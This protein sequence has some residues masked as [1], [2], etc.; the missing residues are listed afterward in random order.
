M[1]RVSS[2]RIG[3]PLQVALAALVIGATALTLAPGQA[4]ARPRRDSGA[5]CADTLADGTI[6]FFLPGETWG[7]G[8]T[9]GTLYVCSVTGQWFVHEDHHVQDRG[10]RP[11]RGGR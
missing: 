8:A 5:R 9:T 11:A 6:A 2:V 10:V 1:N 7:F 3:K 4:E